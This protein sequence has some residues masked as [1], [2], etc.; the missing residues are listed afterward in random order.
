MHEDAIPAAALPRGSLFSGL[1]SC[2]EWFLPFA[3]TSRLASVACCRGL[4]EGLPALS[5]RGFCAQLSSS[6]PTSA[7]GEQCFETFSSL[8]PN[9]ESSGFNLSRPRNFVGVIPPAPDGETK[10]RADCT[11]VYLQKVQVTYDTDFLHTV[12]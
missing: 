5:C 4:E 12:V 11:N 1:V 3:P 2:S 10:P 6:F 9:P 8:S 7:P